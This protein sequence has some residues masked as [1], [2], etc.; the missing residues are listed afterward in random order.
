MNVWTRIELAV[1]S[2]SRH[3]RL[4][5]AGLY[6]HKQVHVYL[7]TQTHWQAP[8]KRERTD[9]HTSEAHDSY[10]FCVSVVTGGSANMQRA[11]NVARRNDA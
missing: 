2:T 8:A 6:T 1:K 7:W 11:F 9:T 5:W 3:S 4:P 10:M